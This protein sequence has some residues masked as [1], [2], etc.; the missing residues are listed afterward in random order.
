[1]MRRAL[2]DLLWRRV[3]P[4]DIVVVHGGERFA[5]AVE[6]FLDK[7]NYPYSR[8][9]S[10]TVSEIQAELAFAPEIHRVHHGY[11]EAP[12]LFGARGLLVT[13]PADLRL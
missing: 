7:V 11:V 4:V 2:S 13:S 3:L 6:V 10:M 8:L 1:M 9:R 12:F 5:Q